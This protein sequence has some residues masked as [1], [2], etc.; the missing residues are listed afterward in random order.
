MLERIRALGRG[1]CILG[2]QERGQILA[3]L[4]VIDE[5]S[6]DIENSINISQFRIRLKGG[7]RVTLDGWNIASFNRMY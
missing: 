7:L 3:V 2:N 6:D 1:D 5:E 4:P